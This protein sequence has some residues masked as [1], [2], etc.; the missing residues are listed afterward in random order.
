LLDASFEAKRLS[1]ELQRVEAVR[2]RDLLQYEIGSKGNTL[3]MAHSLE[4]PDEC[5]SG[6]QP[7]ASQKRAPLTFRRDPIF[8]LNGSLK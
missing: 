6:K 1:G 2:R 5:L 8:P 7:V 4:S 3:Q